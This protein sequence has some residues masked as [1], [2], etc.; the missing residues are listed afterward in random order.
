MLCNVFL[1]T[2]A[3]QEGT[4]SLTP[5]VST[6]FKTNKIASRVVKRFNAGQGYASSIL[7]VLIKLQICLKQASSG[8]QLGFK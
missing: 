8:L 5:S 7:K 1:A 4:V 2:K 6:F 3:A